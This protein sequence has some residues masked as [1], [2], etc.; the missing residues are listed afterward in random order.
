LITPPESILEGIE[1]VWYNKCYYD[2]PNCLSWRMLW[3]LL[4]KTRL[5]CKYCI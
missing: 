1:E 3:T 2:T 4:D 5:A